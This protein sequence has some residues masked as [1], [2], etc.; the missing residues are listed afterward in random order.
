MPQE[1]KK[2]GENESS[3]SFQIGYEETCVKERLPLDRGYQKGHSDLQEPT[4]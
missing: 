2:N 1:Q 4:Y 3:P